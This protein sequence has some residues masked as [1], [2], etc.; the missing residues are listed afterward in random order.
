L[1]FVQTEGVKEMKK[2]LIAS[3]TALA[4]LIAVAL[5][6]AGPGAA[7]A[8]GIT[9]VGKKIANFNII[10]TPHGWVAD[11]SVCPNNGARIFFSADVTPWTILWQFDPA[12]NNFDIYDCNGT[13]DG[14]AVINQDAGVPVDIFIRLQGPATSAIQL[15]CTIP[16]DPNLVNDCYLG[17]YNLSK[18]KTFTKVTTHLFDTV[19]SNVLWTLQNATNF[20]IAQVDVYEH[21]S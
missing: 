3:L 19:Y 8:P 4:L 13:N 10:Q 17:T 2:R 11:D 14:T 9:D 6:A 5:I 16:T 12:Y 1:L 18:S 21:V 20:K 15:V 7:N